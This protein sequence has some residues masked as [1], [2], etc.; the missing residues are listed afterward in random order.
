[1]KSL[2]P[3]VLFHAAVGLVAVL[4]AGSAT[5]GFG[6]LGQGQQVA[7][8]NEKAQRASRAEQL[9][10]VLAGEDQAIDILRNN[11]PE[12]AKGHEPP[13]LSA[14]IRARDATQRLL[15]DVEDNAGD[16]GIQ[17][18]HT[19][20]RVAAKTARAA[21]DVQALLVQA[22]G[23]LDAEYKAISQDPGVKNVHHKNAMKF[24]Q[25]ARGS[26]QNEIEAYARAHPAAQSDAAR[27][28]AAN[29]PAAPAAQVAQNADARIH[30]LQ[31]ILSH[32]DH[33]IDIINFQPADQGDLKQKTLAD[34]IA[35]RNAVRQ[36][37]GAAQNR[38]A[39]DLAKDAQADSARDAAGQ[40]NKP[41]VG[42]EG[43]KQ[44]QEYLNNDH[45]TLT[46]LPDDSGHLRAGALSRL[47]QAQTA[48]QAEIDQFL[49]AH[50]DQKK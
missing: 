3:K 48:I 21:G 16:A 27:A 45:E 35:A 47:E 32:E 10:Q 7:S 13:S 11:E 8:R 2:R 12:G 44:A 34:I 46:R 23:I 22:R 31:A 17:K 26:L 41:L 38:S 37:M 24:L 33:A 1:M 20:D 6:N 9:K 36:L 42:Y 39:A 5:S 4:S 19:G 40:P 18:D 14:L 29:M 49:K 25:E 50:P 43:L 30:D 28:A 15:N